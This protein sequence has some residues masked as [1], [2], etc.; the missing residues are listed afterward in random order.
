M[1]ERSFYGDRISITWS[2]VEDE[3]G[4]V[5]WEKFGDDPMRG[6]LK[7]FLMPAGVDPRHFIADRKRAYEDL[8][9]DAFDARTG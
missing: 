4:I 5:V 1:S 7:K 9:A 3:Y 2:W 8:V 6:E